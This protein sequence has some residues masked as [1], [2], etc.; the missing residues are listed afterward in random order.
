[1]RLMCHMTHASVWAVSGSSRSSLV[2][3]PE[4]SDSSLTPPRPPVSNR[5]G[6]T[7]GP[8]PGWAR[9][10]VP[11]AEPQTEAAAS[12]CSVR[13]PLGPALRQEP[14]DSVLT[15]VLIKPEPEEPQVTHPEGFTDSS[16]Q[17][18]LG[19]RPVVVAAR[20]GDREDDVSESVW[21]CPRC[22]EAF[23]RAGALQLHLQQQRKSYA[24]DRC[25]KSFAQAA[26]LRRHL[27]T[28]TGERPHRCTFCSKSFSQRGNLRRHLRIHTGERPYSCPSCSRTFSD[29]DTL[30]K[31]QRTHA[32][33]KALG[34]SPQGGGVRHC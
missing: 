16:S 32:G 22:G 31:H 25:C 4:E 10:P 11:K 18:P 30:K 19:S 9:E 29:G 17:D 8:S 6:A 26:D 34:S 23:Q 13:S 3:P 7:R 33:Q 15:Q 24:C 12:R 28:H 1:M 2:A 21:R 5:T 14:R 20:S 27:R